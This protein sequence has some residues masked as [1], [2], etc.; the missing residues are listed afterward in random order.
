MLEFSL[1]VPKYSLHI[2]CIHNTKFSINLRI[3]SAN[4]ANIGYNQSLKNRFKSVGRNY[5]LPFSWFVRA[6]LW[7]WVAIPCP[8]P[9]LTLWLLRILSC[10]GT[11]WAHLPLQMSPAWLLSF[12]V[13]LLFYRLLCS[14]CYQGQRLSCSHGVA[15]T[16]NISMSIDMLSLMQVI[17][18]R[19]G[20]D[21]GDN[22]DHSEG[23]I[24]ICWEESHKVWIRRKGGL[25]QG[26]P[27]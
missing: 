21:R 16:I 2:H 5:F 7:S 4:N 13:C 9:L 20:E 18:Y 12:P 22:R 14:T 1:L 17:Q 26:V 3:I 19:N 11:F 24:G 23:N 6:F 10:P 25:P 15:A 8:S 27:W